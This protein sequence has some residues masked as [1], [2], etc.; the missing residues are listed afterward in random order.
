MFRKKEGPIKIGDNVSLE[1][2]D[3]VSVIYVSNNLSYQ[4]ADELREAR[5]QIKYDKILLDLGQVRLTTS[6]GMGALMGI[7]IDAID[8][9]RKVCIC[10]I[11]NHFMN[12]FEAMEL[13]KHVPE[14][15]MFDTIDEGMEYL[16]DS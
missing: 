16:R 4:T 2:K 1:Q 14:I 3:G 12:I 9:N 5:K 6:R 8:N 15:K 13:A 10:N 7:A 11:S